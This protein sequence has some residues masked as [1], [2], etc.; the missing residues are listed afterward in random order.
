MNTRKTPS[1]KLAPKGQKPP[2]LAPVRV[3]HRTH[4]SSLRCLCGRSVASMLGQA[5]CHIAFTSQK[6]T[7]KLCLRVL[8]N[9]KDLARRA[10]DSE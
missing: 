3:L 1:K 10:L 6:V 4:P 8:Q 2:R 7:C 9:D 5:K